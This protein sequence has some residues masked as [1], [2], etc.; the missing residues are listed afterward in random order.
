MA[1]H[2]FRTPLAAILSSVSL[3]SKYTTEEQQPKRDKHISRIK[4]SVQNL[5]II[6]NDFLS[7]DK[8]EAGKVICLPEPFH[9]QKM[10]ELVIDDISSLLKTNQKIAFDNGTEGLNVTWDRNLSR[11]IL[12]NLL[13]NAIKYSD[14]GG[15]VH[16]S[17]AVSGK[18]IVVTVKDEGIGIP[19]EE[20]SHMFERFFRAKNATNLQGT[21]LGLNITKKHVE[22]MGGTIAFSS[23]ANEGSTF[24]VTLPQNCDQL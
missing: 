1:S 16:F 22:L 24:I 10:C 6:L 3:I 23:V 9:L 11:N 20:Q 4:S 19:E 13:S 7:L 21:G 15:T 12:T 2:E 5:T 18:D 8:L 17:T 14:E